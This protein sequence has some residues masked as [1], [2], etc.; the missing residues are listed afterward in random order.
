MANEKKAFKLKE[1][2]SD[3]H[4]DVKH[5]LAIKV[6]DLPPPP[7]KLG[8]SGDKVVELQAALF[9]LH[10]LPA[11]HKSGKYDKYTELALGKFK[12]DW[13]FKGHEGYDKHVRAYLAHALNGEKPNTGNH[14]VD[15]Q[16][17]QPGT[18]PGPANTVREKIVAN[19]WWGV[20]NE[21][22]ITYPP[23]DIRSGIPHI[24]DKH[25]LPLET[26]CSGFATLCYSW[27]GAPDCNGNGYNGQG[28]TGTM[29]A[30]MREIPKSKVKPGDLV[31][32]G[33]GTGNHVCIVVTT[34]SD[35]ELISHGGNSGPLK[36]SYSSE[37]DWQS[38][39]GHGSNPGEVRWLTVFH[40]Q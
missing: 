2:I 13:G 16:D 7:L 35:P 8:D 4:F 3:L 33:G 36:I 12:H 23:H 6:V 18:P 24:H 25:H 34:G 20:H 1:V 9:K 40:D 22:L 5:E 32:F 28:Y 29:L 21:P 14:N 19:A 27:A 10:Y 38:R 39:N 30:H 17:P 31:V 26:D 37:H 11:A 15:G